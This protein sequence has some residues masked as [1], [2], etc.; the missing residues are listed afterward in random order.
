M[1]A[2]PADAPAL[3]DLYRRA[4]LGCER[5]VDPRLV[6]DQT[7]SA[8]DVLAWFHGGFEVFRVRHE[9]DLLGAVR[10]CYP[11]SACVVDQLAVGPEVRGRGVG[12]LLLG[13]AIGR[14]RR[15]GV[16]RVWAQVSPKL[17]P[18]LGLFRALGFRDTTVIHAGYWAEDLL[19]LELPI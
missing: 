16:T 13:H 3:A 10:C 11:S 12:H 8:D 15:A 14:A 6:A 7:P 4:W 17:E 18:S 19:L 1:P 9:G 5:L 2:Q